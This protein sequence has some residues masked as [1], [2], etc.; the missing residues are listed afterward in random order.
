MKTD[1]FE[2][3]DA[4]L[5]LAPYSYPHFPI[6]C[7]STITPSGMIA[8]GKHGVGVLSIGAGLP[9][10]PEAMAKQ[11]AIYEETAA[12]HGHTADRSKWRIVVNAHVAE[13]DEQALREVHA[14][15]RRETVTY[16]EDTL[17]R[18]PGRSD[19][20]L[21]EGVKQG[22]TLVGSPDTVAKGIERLLGYSNGGFG[23]ILFRAHEWAEPRA[24]A[25]L[26]RAVRALRHAAL[27]GLARHHRRL[28]QLGARE[29]QGGVRP[30]RRGGEEGLHRRRPRG[31]GRVPLAHRRARATSRTTRATGD[32][33]LACAGCPL[34]GRALRPGLRDPGAG[35]RRR[36][37][38]R[39]ARCGRPSRRQ[40]S[41]C[42]PT[43]SPRP[44]ARAVRLSF[45]ARICARRFRS[46]RA[47]VRGCQPVAAL[48]PV[49]GDRGARR[50]ASGSLLP[51]AGLLLC[52]LNSTNDHHFGAS[53][54]PPSTRT[55]IS[56]TASPSASSTARRR[57]IGCRSAAVHRVERLVDLRSS[58]EVARGRS[59]DTTHPEVA[60]PREVVAGEGPPRT[61]SCR[62]ARHV[63]HPGSGVC[64][65]APP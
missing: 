18:P 44:G 13:D 22:T 41:I 65:R 53:G 17:G 21:R 51:P 49:A 32:P 19:D 47:G 23:G 30:D 42:R 38:H 40:A 39:G 24:D 12:K 28:E 15:E 54:H 14:G 46:M 6:A 1:W 5:H 61:S 31:A 60:A 11:W 43:R 26:L 55:T 36:P 52:R 25:A 62:P 50:V 63:D 33:W 35:L 7:A 4:R 3:K 56:S 8:A 57:L 64:A 10:G 27:P 37:R 2:L 45:I 16:F 34:I 9:G 58:R 48:F 20:P 29:P 59:R